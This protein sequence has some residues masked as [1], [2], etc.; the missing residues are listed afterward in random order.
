MSK[1]YINITIFIVFS[2][3]LS[4]DT[5]AQTR[6][7]DVI[8]LVQDKYEAID[9]FKAEFLQVQEWTLLEMADTTSGTISLVKPDYLIIESPEVRMMTDGKS[10]WDYKLLENSAIIDIFESG[11]N[12]F[13]PKEFL[14]DFPE[15]YYPVDFRTEQRDG[16]N[17]YVIEME[18]KNP[19]EEFMQ[20]LEVWIE[21]E[22]WVVKQVKYTDINDDI[23]HFFLTNYEINTDISVEDFENLKPG[24]DVSIRDFRKKGGQDQH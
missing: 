24:K 7:R 21:A 11:G 23:L 6:S 13:L 1:R 16:K 17:G 15:R 4:P 14:F 2:M 12:T 18:P 10:V 3:L 9:N 22:I 5:F 8:K 19:D 20:Y